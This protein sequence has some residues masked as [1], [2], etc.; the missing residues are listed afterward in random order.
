MPFAMLKC[1]ECGSTA[2]LESGRKG[3]T[4]VVIMADALGWTYTHDKGWRCPDH[5]KDGQDD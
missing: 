2:A 4:A 1:Q 5:Q 3:S